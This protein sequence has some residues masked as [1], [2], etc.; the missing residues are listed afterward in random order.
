[1]R[2]T[3]SVRSVGES[4]PPIKVDLPLLVVFGAGKIPAASNA[5]VFGEIMHVGIVLLG[6]GVP[7]TMSG[8]RTPPWQFRAS[9][10]L[11]TAATLGTLIVSAPKLPPYVDGSGT[12]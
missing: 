4:F 1:M 3:S 2:T 11:D 9:T 10:A 6:K 12:G 7:C 5:V 8:G